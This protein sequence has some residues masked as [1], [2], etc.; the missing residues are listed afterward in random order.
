MLIIANWKI[1]L[2]YQKSVQLAQQLARIKF[3]LPKGLVAVVCPSPLALSSVAKK[4][5]KS[6]LK[7]G[8]QD[9]F[10]ENAG[11]FTGA[12]SPTDIKHLGGKYVIIGHSARRQHLGETDKM[13]NEKI[14]AA[15]KAGLT[16]ILCI[17]ETRAERNA[18]QATKKIAHQL[19]AGLVKLKL[20]QR[21]KIII[22]YE[23]LWG[24]YPTK[25]TVSP[26]DIET[27]SRFMAK[28]LTKKFS[29]KK[30]QIIYGG[31]VTSQNVNHYLRLGLIDGVLVG[32]ASTNSCEFV[33]IVEKC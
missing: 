27:M 12:L 6:K 20:K 13:I 33:K 22:A 16:P 26:R 18:G 2:N 4:L 24:I 8:A 19:R 5:Q 29:K 15:L 21:Q 17:G 7:L 23:P 28:K 32:H 3:Q 25:L 1:Y 14:R 30:W 31:S 9:C 10:W 11:G